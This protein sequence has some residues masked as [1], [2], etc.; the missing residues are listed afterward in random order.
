MRSFAWVC[1]VLGILV[2][3]GGIIFTFFFELQATTKWDER[4]LRGDFWG[5][6]IGAISSIAGSFLFFA[7]ILF[8]A[9]ELHL[10]RDQL[11]LQRKEMKQAMGIYQK[12][13]AQLE[14]QTRISRH[15]SIFSQVMELVT[16]K[17]RL[18]DELRVIE[19]KLR[20]EE[21][22]ATENDLVRAPR[23]ESARLANVQ[24]L[25]M[26]REMLTRQIN[27]C[28]A[29]HR[30]L[31]ASDYLSEVE[32]THLDQIGGLWPPTK[33]ESGGSTDGSSGPPS[34]HPDGFS[35]ASPRE[36]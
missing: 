20:Q 18:V 28:V 3:I 26:E 29:A 30:R 24:D 4:A 8:Q 14:E 31:L 23:T 35:Q 2:L 6:H 36:C 33:E 7:A 10:Q 13:A 25:R 11:R 9:R 17:L 34:P 5:G 22:L 19:L 27:S 15:D 32:R 1:C 16:F 21:R 12:Q